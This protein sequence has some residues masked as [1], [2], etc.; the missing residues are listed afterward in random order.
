MIKEINLSFVA[1]QDSFHT[2]YVKGGDQ[3]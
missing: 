3:P 2:K 1:I